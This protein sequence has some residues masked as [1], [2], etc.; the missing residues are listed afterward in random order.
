MLFDERN[1]VHFNLEEGASVTRKHTSCIINSYQC[2]QDNTGTIVKTEAA[3]TPQSNNNK[4]A[5]DHRAGI[6]TVQEI[7]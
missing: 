2:K 7:I 4:N 3:R 5:L 6:T 1:Y